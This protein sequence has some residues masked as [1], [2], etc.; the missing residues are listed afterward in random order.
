MAEGEL[1]VRTLIASSRPVHSVL[2]TPTRLETTRDALDRLPPST[3]IYL[4]AQPVMD[5]IVGYHIHRGILAAGIRPVSPSLDSILARARVLVILESLANHDNVG[6]IFRSLAAIVG[7]DSSA[8]LLSPG[9][10]DPLYRKSI[11]VSIGAAL[12]LPWT[13]L[14]PWPIALSRVREAGF[15]LVALSLTQHARD[16]RDL[17]PP[18]RLALLVGAEG[19]GLSSAAATLT[20]IHARIRMHP[21]MDSLNAAVATAVAL[22]HLSPCV[23]NP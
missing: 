22:H 16:L 7:V 9:C 19:P 14:E 1:V 2:V 5:A 17:E 3:P 20:D 4:A 8:V 6:G 12:L 11:R 15:T 21:P 13:V 23:H 10:C 18:R